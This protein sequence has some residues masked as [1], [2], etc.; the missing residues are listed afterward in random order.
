MA[1]ISLYELTETFKQIQ[2]MAEDDEADEQAFLDTLDAIDWT[3]DFE[4]KCDSYVMTI[5]NLELAIGAD[6]GQIAAIEKILENV[7]KSKQAK[8]NRIKNMK[9][10]LCNAMIA[11]DKTKFKS[12]RFSY[13]TQ[14]TSEVVVTDETLVPL[15]MK[16]IPEP[17]ISKK[18]IKD[19]LKNGEKLSFAHLEEHETV[20]FK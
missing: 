14:K 13:W 12:S 16:T 6:D 19:A 9:E 2:A 10:R 15:T 8:E 1:D 20:R 3:T 11:V 5:R 17:K 18:L 7:K 4:S